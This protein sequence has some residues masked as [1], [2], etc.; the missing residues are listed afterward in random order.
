MAVST[1]SVV[2]PARPH[3]ARASHVH[4]RDLYVPCA[5]PASV[6]LLLQWSYIYGFVLCALPPLGTQ[7]LLGQIRRVCRDRQDAQRVGVPETTLP[8]LD[9]HDSRSRLDDVE[10]EGVPQTKPNTVVHLR[11]DNVRAVQ[12]SGTRKQLTSVCHWCASMPR[13]SGYQKG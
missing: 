11:P 13:G 9:R 12:H 5:L 2:S 3:H 7:R 4:C 1:P 8:A 6:V 10:L